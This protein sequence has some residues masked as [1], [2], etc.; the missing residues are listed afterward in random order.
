MDQRTGEELP[1]REGESAPV[2]LAQYSCTQV[3]RTNQPP[4]E[5]QQQKNNNIEMETWGRF[6]Q[7]TTPEWFFSAN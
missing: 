4:I 5:H 3:A 7:T 2:F 6:Q 1:L